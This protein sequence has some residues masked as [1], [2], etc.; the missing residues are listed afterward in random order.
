[1][2]NTPSFLLDAGSVARERLNQYLAE[3][4][5]GSS[6]AV[7][8]EFYTFLLKQA[9]GH[10]PDKSY[11]CLDLPAFK[12]DGASAKESWESYKNWVKNGSVANN[13]RP[14]PSD[15]SRRGEQA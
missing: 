7:R 9:Q 4:L 2:E 15:N 6:D 1:M 10:E 13:F 11:R 3:K 14:P 8:W 5:Y 12:E